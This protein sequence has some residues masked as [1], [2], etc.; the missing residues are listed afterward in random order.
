MKYNYY[1]DYINSIPLLV[2]KTVLTKKPVSFK[3]NILFGYDTENV[4]N[5]INSDKIQLNITKTFSSVLVNLLLKKMILNMNDNYLASLLLNELFNEFIIIIDDINNRFNLSNKINEKDLYYLCMF[6]EIG[7]FKI[8]NFK[9]VTFQNKYQFTEKYPIVVNLCNQYNKEHKHKKIYNLINDESTLLSY[10][11]VWNYFNDNLNTIE[12]YDNDLNIIVINQ[13]KNASLSLIKKKLDNFINNIGNM[14]DNIAIIAESINVI[15]LKDYLKSGNKFS[16]QENNRITPILSDKLFDLDTF[17][18]NSYFK[19]IMSMLFRSFHINLTPVQGVQLSIL[20]LY[21][22]NTIPIQ[23]KEFLIE[24]LKKNQQTDMIFKIFTTSSYSGINYKISALNLLLFYTKPYKSMEIFGYKYNTY[25]NELTK[26]NKINLYKVIVSI[27]L[28]WIFKTKSHLLKYP[29]LKDFEK[30]MTDYINLLPLDENNNK[31][32]IKLLWSKKKNINIYLKN[33]N[34]KELE[35]NNIIDEIIKTL[36]N[37]NINLHNVN[38]INN[39]DNILGIYK[40]NN[41]SPPSCDLF[42]IIKK[43]MFGTLLN[44]CELCDEITFNCLESSKILDCNQ[45]TICY[46]CY[47]NLFNTN[48]Y[49][50]GELVNSRNFMCPFCLTPH[51]HNLLKINDPGEYYNDP[52]N[53]RLCSYITCNS[54]VKSNTINLCNLNLE[55][56][57]SQQENQVPRDAQNQQ[58]HTYCRQHQLMIE[59]MSVIPV[60][61]AQEIKACPS[62]N[63]TINKTEGCHH[64]TCLCG[65]QFCWVCEYL[66]KDLL[67]YNH[68][69]Y[70]RGNYG[71][72]IGLPAMHNLLI[73][74]YNQLSELNNNELTQENLHSIFGEYLRTELATPQINAMSYWGLTQWLK[75][76]YNLELL[77]PIPEYIAELC[78]WVNKQNLD[79]KSL[80]DIIKNLYDG[81]IAFKDASPN[82]F[83]S[84]N[85]E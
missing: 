36:F 18:L 74:F 30:K 57:E 47:N 41:E 62:C 81:F 44:V 85:S 40:I 6:F 68:Q 65:T 72:L 23:F 82:L 51:N 10:N 11:I 3:F 1:M 24:S 59:L 13:S 19:T 71:W 15:S 70:C 75:N 67:T 77:I 32:I 27:F 63:L 55:Q 50:N 31:Q 4:I 84:S 34:E 64:M 9:N 48:P 79:N 83:S 46:S 35:L 5:L 17:T 42:N 73:N 29:K 45:H 39:N 2:D 66:Q 76:N 7:K 49:S 80:Y 16:Y 56:E 26:I 20:L 14:S 25:I 22:D 52:H 33:I 37:S 8:I 12:N 53:Y 54:V 78:E 21:S 28:N 43:E 69:S 58:E 61:M 38:D 60:D